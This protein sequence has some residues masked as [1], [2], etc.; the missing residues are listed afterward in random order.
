MSASG[1]AVATATRSGPP[2]WL[3][4]A[5]FTVTTVGVSISAIALWRNVHLSPTTTS[6][7]PPI[8]G[9]PQVAVLLHGVQAAVIFFFIVI[10]RRWLKDMASKL[11]GAMPIAKKT[12]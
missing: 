3:P 6:A 2:S 12:L 5:Q 4:F 9:G 10:H 1:P 8:R 11:T 7:I